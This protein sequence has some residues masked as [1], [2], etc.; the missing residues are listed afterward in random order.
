[1]SVSPVGPNGFFRI[2]RREKRNC[3]RTPGTRNTTFG[4]VY[5]A[6]RNRYLDDLIN[7][8]RRRLGVKTFNRKNGSEAA[9]ALLREPGSVGILVDQSAGR[10]EFLTE[11]DEA[12]P[13]TNR[14]YERS[15]HPS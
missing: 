11:I 1:R 10:R 2:A 4:T 8:H 15:Q 13:L 3:E 9:L 5:Q 14:S 7:R 12:A 6:S